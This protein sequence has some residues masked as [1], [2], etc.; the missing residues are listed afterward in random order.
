MDQ[1]RLVTV[2]I[3]VAVLSVVVVEGYT[4]LGLVG[5]HLGGGATPTDTATADGTVSA[6]SVG[7]VTQGEEL[8]PETD[9]VETVSTATLSGGD[10]WTLTVTVSVDN[11]GTTPYELALG[12]VTLTGGT[13][14][15][16]SATTGSIPPGESGLVSAQWTLPQGST[17]AALGVTALEHRDGGTRVVVER[18]VPL[19]DVPV[20]G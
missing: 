12:N 10:R 18:T 20:Q 9:R 11:T 2:L 4:F 7:G 17:P 13:T 3:A 16:G 19:G 14:V 8:L 5:N 6:T 1:R 15:A